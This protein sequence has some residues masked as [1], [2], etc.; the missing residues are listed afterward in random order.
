MIE[1]YLIVGHAESFFFF[2]NL[3]M[4]NSNYRLCNL[5]ASADEHQSE[6]AGKASAL[7]N[8]IPFVTNGQKYGEK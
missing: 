1:M 3:I 6:A 2:L 5:N 8:V 4:S 7:I